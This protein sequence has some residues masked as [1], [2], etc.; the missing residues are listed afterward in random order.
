MTTKTQT[1]YRGKLIQK[2]SWIGIVG[3]AFL[4][5]LK[6]VV[7]IVAGS[8]A[9]I[10]DGIDSATDI[11]SS[12]ITYFA[13]RLSEQPP[14][15]AHPWGHNRIEAIA[16]KIIAIIILFAGLQLVISTIGILFSNEVREMPGKAAIAV[17]LLSI[18]GKAAIAFYK[19]RVAKKANSL[20]VKADAINMKNDIFL[21]LAV[22]LGLGITY[23]TKLPIIDVCVGIALGLYIIKS[24]TE[25]AIE[26]NTELMDS[27]SDQDRL[28]KK[29]FAIV[30][31][32]PGVSNPH[33]ARIRKLNHLFDISLDVEVDGNISVN[34]G[35]DLAMQLEI[36]IKKEFKDVFDVMV[37]IEPHANKEKEQFGLCS[38]DF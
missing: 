30:D 15:K 18:V 8:A 13:S 23:L 10:A 19:F 5:T 22:L 32:T 4:A 34:E 38:D 1:S 37:H 35:H 9:V 28:Y 24:G 11:L 36:N 2:A 31:D 6:I 7:G 25:L 27:F 3:N 20:M 21:S 26:T 33:R 29:L 16:T 17:T 12:L 14:D